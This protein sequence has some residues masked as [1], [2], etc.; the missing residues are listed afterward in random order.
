M[1][2]GFFAAEP[3]AGSGAA[4]ATADALH[5]SSSGGAQGPAAPP[6]AAPPLL[7]ADAFAASWAQCL[8]LLRADSD[9]K[10]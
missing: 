10:K 5:A 2:R 3:G 4:A 6:A 8:E 1:R 9:E 7:S